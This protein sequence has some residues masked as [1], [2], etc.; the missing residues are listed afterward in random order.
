MFSKVPEKFIRASNLLI[1]VTILKIVNIVIL[2]IVPAGTTSLKMI[3]IIA[4]FIVCSFVLRRGYKWFIYLMPL[5]MLF[6]WVLLQTNIVHVFAKNPLAGIVTGAQFLLQVVIME[7][8][9]SPSRSTEQGKHR[10]STA[11]RA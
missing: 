6:P 10:A 1:F 4:L 7:I 8:L 9:L 11:A 5:I 2:D 3:G